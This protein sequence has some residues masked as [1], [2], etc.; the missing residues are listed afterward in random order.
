MLD[1]L[2]GGAV[3]P[4]ERPWKLW[5]RYGSGDEVKI[6]ILGT[7]VGHLISTID[8][9]LQIETGLNKQPYF[10]RKVLYDNL[11]AEVLPEFRACRRGLPRPG[12]VGCL[13]GGEG[14]R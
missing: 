9:N 10:Q 14:P 5:L 1:E 6:H 3:K 4:Q 7:D 12:K 13:A 11:P 8:H 2:C